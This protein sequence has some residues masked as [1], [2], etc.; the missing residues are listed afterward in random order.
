MNE[1]MTLEDRSFNYILNYKLDY[2]DVELKSNLQ[3]TGCDCTDNCQNKAKCSCWQLT[4]QRSLNRTLEKDDLKNKN[5]GYKNMRLQN[6]VSSG[7]V[8]CAAN[9]KCCVDKCVNR[10][11]QHGLQ[12]ELELFK[13]TNRGW[14]V[15]T[16]TDLPPGVFICNYAGDILEE[17]VADKRS[18]K[19]QFKVP[20]S[21]GD[22]DSDD[23]ENGPNAEPRPKR[24]K[25][26]KRYD[27]IQVMV[28]YFPP[29]PG[30]N[31]NNYPDSDLGGS[32]SGGY[33]IDALNHGNISRFFNV[34]HFYEF[35]LFCSFYLFNCYRI[36]FVYCF[37]I[38]VIQ[39]Y[40]CKV[41]M[42]EMISVFP[43]LHFSLENRLRPA[44]S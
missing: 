37:S 34:S 42:L 40:L 43:K 35:R 44:K 10:I 32:K 20:A 36:R 1:E 16:K 12:H 27:V 41:Y 33:I 6:I 4:V 3:R 31:T 17:S 8:E 29:I 28:N 39:I 23:D 22:N 13:T 7:I 18:T 11:V 25:H 19:Y 26:L 15:R 9:C 38:V 24:S 30:Y 2:V 5:I 21:A 14:G